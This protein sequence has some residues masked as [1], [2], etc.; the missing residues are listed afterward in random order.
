MPTE[1]IPQQQWAQFFDDFSQDHQNW[2]ASVEVLGRDIGDQTEAANVPL[3]GISFD[4]FG[5][6]AGDIEIALGDTAEQFQVHRVAS[7]THVRLVETQPG[8]EVDLQI[9]SAEGPTTLVHL[10]QSAELPPSSAA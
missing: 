5:S 8:R 4:E 7:P 6:E 9:E 3:Q 10:R 1:E 2:Q